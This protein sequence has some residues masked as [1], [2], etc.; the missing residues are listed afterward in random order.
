MDR[1]GCNPLYPKIC[2]LLFNCVIIIIITVTF[3][4]I[5]SVAVVRE[6]DAGNACVTHGRK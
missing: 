6:N 3:S 1:G 2:S 5:T 4:V